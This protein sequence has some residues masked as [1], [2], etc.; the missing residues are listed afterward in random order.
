V[1]EEC[2]LA[3]RSLGIQSLNLDLIYGLP[4][5]TEASV[6]AT[7]RQA[8]KLNA[9]RVAVFGYAHVPWMKKHQTLIAEDSLPGALARFRQQQAIHKVLTEEG[10]YIAIGLD[11]YARRGDAMAEAH[12]ARH[13]RRGFQG[14]TTDDAPVLIGFGASAIGSLPQGYV[15]NAPTAAAYGKAIESGGLA[16]VRGVS[17]D[18][19][20]R[21]RR[22]V[23][24]RLMCDLEVDLKQVASAH[25]A[26]P[27][28]LLEQARGVARFQDDGLANF[29]GARIEVAEK[30][31]PFL[32]SLAALF[33][34]Y[35]TFDEQKPRHSRAI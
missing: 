9:D 33:D 30:G 13:L 17:L 24:E 3:A 10:G 12:L 27:A 16:T 26:D 1:T 34:A 7:A 6:I 15:Q 14:Y 23:I 31:R 25:G 11:H 2:A 5:Q 18:A 29:D 32:R 28:P 4:L 22:E 20:D 21:M 19:D 8:L 35:L